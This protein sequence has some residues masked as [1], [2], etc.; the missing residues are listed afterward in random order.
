MASYPIW[1]AGRQH[2]TQKQF[3]H[4]SVY[5]E[6]ELGQVHLAGRSE[7]NAALSAAAMAK[8]P[9]AQS[10]TTTR[11]NALWHIV[12]ALETKAEDFAHTICAETGKPISLARG[13]V[14]RAINTFTLCAQ[15]PK[16]IRGEVIPLDINEASSGKTGI[17]RRVPKG[18][19]VAITPFNFPIN[20]VAHKIGPAIAAGCPFVLKPAPQAPVTAWM[21]GEILSE[22]GLPEGAFSVL[23]CDNEVAEALATD[24]RVAVVSFTGSDKVGWMLREKCA[25]KSVL[26]E[27]GG[28]A[29]VI[30]EPD[31]DIESVAQRIVTGA[32]S[33]AGQVCIS[34]QRVL[35]HDDVADVLLHRLVELTETLGFG[36]PAHEDV[37]VGPM[38]DEANA[39]RVDEWVNQA[40]A[41]GAHV[42][43]G[44]YREGKLYR[45]TWLTDVPNDALVSCSEVFG[46]VAVLGKYRDFEAALYAVNDS[47]FGLQA[48]V[49]T[50]DIRKLWQAFD[51]LEVGAIIH[52]DIPT[53]RV[54]H[55]P[56]GGV[57]DSG[58]G[59]EGPQYVVEDFTEPR[60]LA[61]RP[62]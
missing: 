29:A 30:V 14:A 28:N 41:S 51:L 31:C 22:A 52:N 23:P 17:V 35:V 16:R 15:E 50:N 1:L 55:M 39:I 32:F 26:L 25:R 62:R 36:D 11:E 40:R 4:R 53:F 10:T 46:P 34:V 47:Q 42:H 5:D 33:H 20:L 18:I 13:E 6:A 48:G 44:G 37:L 7:V 59:R 27:L 12:H 19:V 38:I 8:L 56:Y 54:D 2:L 43:C 3:L 58:I 9:M 49:F 60:L 21:L 24:E 45:P 57:K 61:L